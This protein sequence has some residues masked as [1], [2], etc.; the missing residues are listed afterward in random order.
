VKKAILFL[1]ILAG[2]ALLEPRSRT[3]IMR[4]VEPIGVAGR[5]HSAERALKRIAEDVQQT[6]AETGIYPQPGD[7]DR[8][9]VQ[10]HGSAE[11]PWGSRYYLELFADS[12]VV[13]SPGP[14]A[15]RQTSDDLRLS[16][17]RSTSASAMRQPATPVATQPGYSPP[18]PP[19]SGVK[20]KAIERARRAREQ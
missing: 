20:S 10:S 3:Q 9:L 19:S 8:W 5:E 17:R 7:F 14:D 2:L 13:G 6:V 18:A 15:R 1:V 11:D 12:F 16:Q 4:L